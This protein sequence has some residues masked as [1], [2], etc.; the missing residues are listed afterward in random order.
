MTQAIRDGNHVT[1]A[2]GVDSSDA[3]NTL[4]L[5]VDSATGRLLTNSASGSGDVVGPAS[6]TNNAVA[7]FDTTTGKLIQ[8]SAVIVADT[9]GVISGTEGI[10]LSGTTSGTTAVIATAIAGTTIITLPAATDTLVGKATTDTFTN[11]TFDAN[12]TGNSLSNIDIAD[13][14]VGTDGELITWD[15][16]GL[17]A[18]VA[19]GTSAQVLT[20]NGA[21]TAPTFQSA[22]G[23]GDVSKVGT[24]VNS[25]VA[26]WTGD[27]TIEGATSLTYDGSN[28]QLTGDIGSTGTRI[29][30]GW[31]ADLTVTNAITGAV[32]GNA[33]TATALATGRTIGGTSFDGTA[34]IAIGALNI[35]NVGATT[36]AELAGV[37]SNETGSGLLVFATSPTLITPILGT[38]TSG[39]ATNITG[40]PAA[41]VLAGSLGTGAYVMDSSLQ[42]STVELGHA[43]DSTISRVSAGILAVEGNNIITANIASSVTVAGV[44]ELAT[45]AEIDTGTDT[46]R[47]IPTDQFVASKRNIRWLVFNV[48]DRLT[49]CSVLANVGG[50]FLSP[51]AGTILQSDTTPFYLYAT[52][53]TAGTTGTM[54]VDIHLNGTTI[55]TTNKLDFDTT[56]KTTTTAAT[57]PDL[58][59]TT[60]AVGDII[61]IDIDSVHTTA[62]KGLTVY[63]GIRE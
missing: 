5:K 8:D 29:T 46:T 62:A 47:A 42:V 23:G 14:A 26:V 50:D 56:E 1:V 18:T 31:L 20:S 32:T 3:T 54:V 33:G 44:V 61:T 12:G 41:S 36:S 11:K 48:V 39:V 28:L 19:T 63:I 57:P 9:T 15:S 59:N 45:T 38:P 30:K 13:L 24:P 40:L 10:T 21:G 17:P 49:D 4:P 37:M 34:N 35:T 6:A 53:T 51:I 43:T 2:I 58:T 16:A 7:R 25:Q 22:A 60:L 52:N 55:M 27:G